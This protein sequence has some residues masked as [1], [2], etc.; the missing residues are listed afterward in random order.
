MHPMLLSGEV[1]QPYVIRCLSRVYVS[2]FAE[3][4][5]DT[6]FEVEFQPLTSTYTGTVYGESWCN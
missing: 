4:V 1:I 5:K 2:F 6:D 3:S